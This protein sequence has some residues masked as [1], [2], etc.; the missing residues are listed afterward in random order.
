MADKATDGYVMNQTMLRIKDPKV[1]VGFYR[2]TLGME[3]LGQFDFEEM[4]FSLYF[5]GYV[6]DDEKI[7]EDKSERASWIFSQPALVELTHNWGT[8]SDPDFAGYHDG[9]SQPQGFGH[10]GISVPDVYVASERFEKLGVEFVKRPDDGKMKGLA[11]IKDPDGYWIEILSPHGLR[12]IA[13][14]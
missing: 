6:S 14:S 10:I 1:S 11:F 7:P 5:M 3:L 8:E 4:K 13:V 12:K 9:N 2:D